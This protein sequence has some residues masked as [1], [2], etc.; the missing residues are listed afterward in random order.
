VTQTL[1]LLPGWPKT[2]TSALQ[3]WL[4]LNRNALGKQGI[5]YHSSAEELTP[6]SEEASA[7]NAFRLAMTLHPKSKPQIREQVIHEFLMRAKT[8]QTPWVVFASEAFVGATQENL[9]QLAAACEQ[10]GFQVQVL[11]YL[12]SLPE[13]LLSQWR[14]RVKLHGESGSA[15][16]SVTRLSRPLRYVK[17]IRNF[18]EVWGQ[19]QVKVRLYDRNAFPQGDIIQDFLQAMNWQLDTA[20]FMPL[21]QQV[22]A[23]LNDWGTQVQRWVNDELRNPALAGL[24][25]RALLAVQPPYPSAGPNQ[26]LVD[27]VTTRFQADQE[28]LQTLLPQWPV[29]FAAAPVPLLQWTTAQEQQVRALARNLTGCKGWQ[30][31]VAYRLGSWNLMAWLA[32]RWLGCCLG[33]QAPRLEYP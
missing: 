23:S 8:C 32:R 11:F 26:E 24:F 27:L 18:Q 9:L 16:A 12:R 22:N 21:P 10:A 7:G 31:K 15:L 14:Q 1:L 5:C 2:G 30:L 20:T 3:G 4:N 25:S 6:R 17:A 29:A 33:E 19:P 28:F 13:F